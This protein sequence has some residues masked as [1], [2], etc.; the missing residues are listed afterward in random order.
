MRNRTSKGFRA[1]GQHG[2]RQDWTARRITLA[3][4]ALS[5][6]L[7]CF[8]LAAH[9]DYMS[10][11]RDSLKKGD[12]KSAQI[13]LRNAV[14]NDPQNAE[15]HYLLGRVSM[16]LGDPVAAEREAEAARQ[17]GFDPHQAIPLLTQA[18]LAQNK[19]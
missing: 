5:T 4:L 18:L 8:P 7:A 9:A 3:G 14:R 13:D 16:E 15:A 6:G 19:Y 10:N 12:L 17:R 1:T 11:A 2:D